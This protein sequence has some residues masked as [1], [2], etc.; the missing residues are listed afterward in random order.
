MSL[1]DIFNNNP[2]QLKGKQLQQLIAFS[3]SGVLSDK[4]NAKDEL[5]EY[6]SNVD[7]S[8][9]QRYAEE[10]LQKSFKDSGLALQDIVNELGKRIGAKVTPGR[11]RGS[12]GEIGNDGLWVFPEGNSIVIEVKTTDAY[13]I[14]L[15]TI[16]GYW[17][18]LQEK[19]IVKKEDSSILIVVGRQD[20]GD[21]EAQIRGSKYAWDVRLISVDALIRLVGIK[22]DLE[23]P[24]IIQQIHHIL[25]PRE[26]T[27]LDDI[28]ELL[29][30]TTADIKQEEE[31][32]TQP[33]P[34]KSKKK[35]PKFV[36]V[37]F[38]QQ[39]VDVVASKIGAKLLK[40]SRGKFST[41]DETIALTC[42]VSKEHD[43][44]SYPN[45]WFAFHPHQKDFLQQAET[46]WAVFGC[47]SSS[48][49]IM[50]PINTLVDWLDGLWVTET[51]EGKMYWHVVIYK[52]KTG[53]E[54]RRKKGND[55]ID[56]GEFVISQ[57]AV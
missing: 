53:Y 19:G 56:L 33:K 26:Y 11:Y 47:G 14:N 36:P 37:A 17:K 43:S 54:L 42:S 7:T 8:E 12:V 24:N 15:T 32:E 44:D 38:H 31:Q 52:T 35:K 13:R 9:L 49:T 55:R 30:S 50:I 46:S 27:R 28:A 34:E 5:R 10:C 6:L 21:L 45:Y 39:C 41:P 4:G 16:H 18:A 48:V 25:V 40:R 20:T 51:P 1:L 2:E 22:E 3:G 29:F 57:G 23:D